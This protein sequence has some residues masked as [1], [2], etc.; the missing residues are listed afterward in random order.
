MLNYLLVPD[1]YSVTSDSPYRSISH[2]RDAI[3]STNNVG[4]RMEFK[5]AQS[6]VVSSQHSED[7]PSSSGP[8]RLAATSS[9]VSA[10]TDP[11]TRQT[12]PVSSINREL[13]RA[14]VRPI[15]P[16]NETHSRNH[17]GSVDTSPTSIIDTDSVVHGTKRTASGA[18]KVAMTADCNPATNSMQ[19]QKQHTRHG[20]LDSRV[21]KVGNVSE[22]NIC[23][24]F[25]VAM[26]TVI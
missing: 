5:Y 8:P 19:F 10:N 16:Q 25:S 2:Q 21:G 23:H 15:T 9:N 24:K 3:Q 4:A 13:V 12:S 11:E 7:S 20:S 14:G 17:V 26:L 1:T 22:M 6:G 18:F